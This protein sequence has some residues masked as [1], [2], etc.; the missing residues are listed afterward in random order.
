[1]KKEGIQTRRRK[2]KKSK[3]PKKSQSSQKYNLSENG[4]ISVQSNLNFIEDKRNYLLFNN[5]RRTNE[6]NDL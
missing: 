2:S 5:N 1:M 3:S 4:Y 6:V